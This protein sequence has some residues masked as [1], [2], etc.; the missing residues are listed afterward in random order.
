[1][2]F[3]RPEAFISFALNRSVHKAFKVEE[4]KTEINSRLKAL[5]KRMESKCIDIVY[6]LILNYF[7]FYFNFSLQVNVIHTFFKKVSIIFFLL[8]IEY[9]RAILFQDVIRNN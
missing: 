8:M 9:Q 2:Y 3:P 7:S 5:E 1:M 4:M 6:N